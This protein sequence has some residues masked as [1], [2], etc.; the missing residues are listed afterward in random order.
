MIVKQRNDD[1]TLIDKK[2]KAKQITCCVLVAKD[3]KTLEKP[4]RE[5]EKVNNDKEK[6]CKRLRFHSNIRATRLRW[7]SRRLADEVVSEKQCL[8]VLRTCLSWR[9]TQRHNKAKQRDSLGRE[10]NAENIQITINKTKKV[11][12]TKQILK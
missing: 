11:A 12:K 10:K 1:K 2:N 4:K 3:A 7:R 6:K 5:S 8:S 9:R